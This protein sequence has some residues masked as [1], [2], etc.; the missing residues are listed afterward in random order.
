MVENNSRL[1]RQPF[2]I[3]ELQFVQC[4][5]PTSLPR[6]RI[7]ECEVIQFVVA[8]C[9]LVHC[10]CLCLITLGDLNFPFVV[11]ENVDRLQILDD[12]TGFYVRKL[13]VE[14]SFLWK[15][16]GLAFI[17]LQITI[18]SFFGFYFPEGFSRIAP[19]P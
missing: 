15:K 5:G 16:P 8:A 7:V 14:N 11:F 6:G 13:I 10:L 3:A 12:P 18:Y 17:R 2:A 19:M 1:T 4:S 9:E